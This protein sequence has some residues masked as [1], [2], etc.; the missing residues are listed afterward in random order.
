MPLR[1]LNE[2]VEK[3][4]RIIE[5]SPAY[6]L[7]WVID[8]ELQNHKVGVLGHMVCTTEAKVPRIRATHGSIGELRGRMW[9]YAQPPL[10]EKGGVA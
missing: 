6:H 4:N 3:T 2:V 5:A 7:R 9:K 8:V 1:S 10:E